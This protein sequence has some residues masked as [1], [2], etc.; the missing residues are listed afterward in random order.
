MLDKNAP[1]I[2]VVDDDPTTRLM[3]SEVL[4]GA[5]FAVSEADRGDA[6]LDSFLRLKPDIVMLDVI[7][8]GMDG[9]QVC[10]ALRALPD[11][12]S[13]PVIMMTGLNDDDSVR[14]AY[15][16]G[17][18]QF[19]SKPI[20]WANLAHQMNYILR[21]K[22]TLERLRESET[23]LAEAQRIAGIGSW[24]LDT[25]SGEMHWS[26]EVY[27]ILGIDETSSG[28]SFDVFLE[29]LHPNDRIQVAAA[30]RRVLS[31]NDSLSIDCR[32]INRKR[33]NLDVHAEAQVRRD[34]S[35][36]PIKAVGYIQDVTERRS[37]EEKIRRLAYFDSLTGLPNRVHFADHFDQ[38]LDRSRRMNRKLSILFVDLDRFKRINDN[39]GH[40]VGDELLKHVAQRLSS[41]VRTSDQVS[42]GLEYLFDVKVSRLA[43]DEF[44]IMVE[45]IRE[46]QDAA[47]IAHRILSALSA[48]YVIDGVE[49][50]VT[51]CIGISLYPLDG[52]E[53][54]EL[55][56]LADM[57][58]Y[59]VKTA[60][61]GNFSFYSEKLNSVAIEQIDRENRLRTALAGEEFSLRY[62]PILDME[63][64]RLVCVEALLRWDN[65][66][67]GVLLPAE[68]LPL[69]EKSGLG[70]ELDEWVLRSAAGQMKLWSRQGWGAFRM[71]VNISGLQARKESLLDVVR[72]V[73]D[74]TGLHP[75]FLGLEFTEHALESC[76]A[77]SVET[78]RRLREMG[79]R[80]AVD[81]FGASQSS[82]NQ[83]KRFPIDML[84]IAK[85]VIAN[86]LQ[87]P[88][89]RS[90]VCAIIA[91]SRALG[92]DSVAAGVEQHEQRELLLSKG[93]GKMQG[94]LINPPMTASDLEM[95]F[96]A[97]YSGGSN[98]FR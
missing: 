94:Y 25:A 77:D 63:S 69:A 33:R 54:D 46:Y 44:L 1:L 10:E 76:R 5:G 23:R 88:D 37:A 40:S 57:A 18:T 79:V 26:E 70:G 43:G 67:K 29:C 6:V 60:G 30:M 53:K 68:F 61:G 56:R 34:V 71:S 89:T 12:D 41:C 17:A 58:M 90:L 9:F 97:A 20:H 83:L 96:H 80:L 24:E 21:A 8:P 14:K 4:E 62:Q 42:R 31:G 32:I 3:V 91:A 51:P 55:I 35:G 74:D 13:I 38:A 16:A 92:L 66:E 95:Y 65:P 2:L 78:L 72:R 64:G 19:I 11:G 45:N 85:S 86:M 47:K 73:L 15:E 22:K 27:R 39:Y 84:K 48:P 50:K 7:M 75:A 49:I 98:H 82:I 87:D 81:D 28:A 93:C 36:H 59:K 52:H